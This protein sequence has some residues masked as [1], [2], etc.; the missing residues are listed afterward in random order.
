MVNNMSEKK[1]LTRGVRQ[2]FDILS[3][4]TIFKPSLSG[5]SSHL[6]LS[7]G[8][9]ALPKKNDSIA[10]AGMRTASKLIEDTGEFVRTPMKW[11]KDI[12]ANWLIYII[13]AAIICLS[14]LFLYCMVR[15]YF[16]SKLNFNPGFTPNLAD[17][18]LAM[19]NNSNHQNSKNSNATKQLSNDR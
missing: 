12:Q 19:A 14:I 9:S 4:K 13:C 10:E 17:I 15:K 1:T 3:H 5:S 8:D 6:H 7:V 2:I 18:A 16:G 11:I